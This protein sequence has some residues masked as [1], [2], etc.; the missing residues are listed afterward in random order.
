MRERALQYLNIKQ[1]IIEQ[2][3]TGTLQAA[4]KLPA[5]RKLAEA[6]N[7]TRVTLREALSLLEAEGRI[8]REDR[9]GW[10]IA[11][12]PF[13]YDP[14]LAQSFNQRAQQQQRQ[15]KTE[16][17]VA[18]K[19][20]AVKQPAQWLALAPFS[21]MYRIDR[22]RYLDNRPVVYTETYLGING[23][24]TL[25]KC[26]LTGS[27]MEIYQHY[28]GVEYHQIKYRIRSTILAG[29]IAIALR[30][31]TG[32]PILV[33]ER[34]HYNKAGEPIDMHIEYWRHDAICI[35]SMTTLKLRS[36]DTLCF[37]NR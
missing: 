10:F 36:D 17:V 26:D 3:E 32:T 7:T 28:F 21:E 4:Q 9:R 29:D 1:A 34:V 35:E 5:E 23:F 14:A 16:L 24:S 8:Y 37:F 11:A 6:F 22:L 15:P 20:L 12:Q 2:I 31:T 25:L 30:S 13:Y 33:I 18:K 19:M 27:L